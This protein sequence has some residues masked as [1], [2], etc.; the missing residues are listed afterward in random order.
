MIAGAVAAVLLAWYCDLDAV[1]AE[2]FSG[3]VDRS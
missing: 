3:G 2:A 1:G